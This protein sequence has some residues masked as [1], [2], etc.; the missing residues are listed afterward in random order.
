MTRF[1]A[2]LLLLVGCASDPLS[3]PELSLAERFEAVALRED[4]RP[5][6]ELVKWSVPIRVMI[7][8]SQQYRSEVASHL[9][10]LGQLTGLETEMDSL[11]PNMLV[12]FSLRNE[13]AWCEVAVF[14]RNGRLRAEITIRTDQSDANIRRCIVQEMTQALGLAE[15]LDGR[16]DTTFSSGIGTDHL[17]DSDRQLVAI[18][19][20]DRLYDGMLRAKVLAILPEI[21]ADVEA[22]QATRSQ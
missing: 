12:E 15:D 13:T 18:L 3:A 11:S 22:A 21:V 9:Q 6:E 5:A 20:D 16:R 10:L 14:G 19:Y 2:V 1:S 17:T 8:G 4:G 7:L